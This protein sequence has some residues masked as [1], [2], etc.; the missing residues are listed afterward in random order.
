MA[1]IASNVATQG[2]NL[3]YN[4]ATAII[5]A[6]ELHRNAQ[7]NSYKRPTVIL[8]RSAS[9]NPTFKAGMPWLAR[10]MASFC[11]GYIY[12][13]LDRASKLLEAH[14][15]LLSPIFIDP[16]SLRD[17]D[18]SA[19]STGYELLLKPPQEPMSS[20]ADLGEAFCEVSRRR[21]EFAGKG[22]GPS[23]TGKVTTSW[24]VLMG[25]MASGMKARMWG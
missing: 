13:D 4:T 1:C 20:Y 21:D 14:S 19:G 6:L 8:L 24:G 23:A 9:V 7:D 5:S 11:F 25:Y 10:N 22:V 16:A 12:E 18:G 17:P 2:I 3:A 15:D